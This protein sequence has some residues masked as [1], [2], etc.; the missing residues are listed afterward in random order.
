MAFLRESIGAVLQRAKCI[1]PNLLGFVV[2]F[3]LAFLLLFACLFVFM[4]TL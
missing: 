1:F 3:S 4:G 2:V